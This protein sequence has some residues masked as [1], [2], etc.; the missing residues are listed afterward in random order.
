MRHRVFSKYYIQI[1]AW[2]LHTG[3]FQSRIKINCIEYF[4]SN[5]FTA[6]LFKEGV[7]AS[8]AA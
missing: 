2:N 8:I 1:N 3:K 4:V 6:I 5:S 7:L